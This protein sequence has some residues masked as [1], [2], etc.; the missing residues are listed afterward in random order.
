MS[1]SNVFSKTVLIGALTL[2]CGAL[3]SAPASAQT[4]PRSFYQNAGANC[5]GVDTLSDSK[6]TRTANRLINKTS[7][8]VDVVCNLM[9]DVYGVSGS[10]FGVVTYVALWARRY[11]GSGKTMSCTLSDGFYGQVGATVYQPDGAN[12]VTLP[13]SG[14]QAIFEWTPGGTNRFLGPVNIRCTLPGNTELND[15]FVEYDVNE[16]A[17][18]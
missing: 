16:T 17:P 2:A 14:A 5:H 11:A 10:N 4:V 18:V 9:T 13:N 8:S 1:N 6:L 12:P 3:Y 15:W 7:S